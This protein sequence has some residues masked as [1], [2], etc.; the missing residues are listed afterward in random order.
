M[1]KLSILNTFSSNKLFAKYLVID[2]FLLEVQSFRLAAQR[3]RKYRFPLTYPLWQM[4]EWLLSYR[5]CVCGPHL[6]T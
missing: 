3:T 1:H 5:V 6:L 2:T 4:I